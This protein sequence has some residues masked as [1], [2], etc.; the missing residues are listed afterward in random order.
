MRLLT[1]YYDMLANNLFK[2]SSQYTIVK[3]NSL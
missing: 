1:V 3:Q 2:K